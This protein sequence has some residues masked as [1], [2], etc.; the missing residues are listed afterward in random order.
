MLSKALHQSR[1]IPTC[2]VSRK[3]VRRIRRCYLLHMNVNI[4]MVSEGA[5]SKV[6]SAKGSVST[7]LQR[8]FPLD[9]AVDTARLISNAPPIYH[10]GSTRIKGHR[11]NWQLSVNKSKGTSTS[12]LIINMAPFN[13]GI[14]TEKIVNLKVMPCF[15]VSQTSMV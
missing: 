9:S 11:N 6:T 7:L 15:E 3:P 8:K 14:A 13:P 4:S 1:N 10:I 5:Q 2:S 12:G